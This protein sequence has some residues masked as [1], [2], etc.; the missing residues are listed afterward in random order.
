MNPR[1]LLLELFHEALRSVDGER[2][3]AT[4]LGELRPGPVALFAI[5]K[6]A[7]SMT[8]GAFAALGDDVQQTLIITKDGHVDP[9]VA[10]RPRVR[11]IE[12]AHPIPDERSL[13]AGAELE[14][15][16]VELPRG[17]YP[18]FLVSGGSSSLV[19]SLRAG[20]TL[21][22]LRSLNVR[23]MG[24]GWDIARLN[25]ERGKLS[26]IKGG[27]VAALLDGRP[28]HAL[29]ISDV[30]GDDP[31]V[32][33][34][35][36]LGPA[37]GR[38]DR[39]HRLVV[40]NVGAATRCVADAARARGVE[41]EERRASF[42]GEAANVA[43]EFLDALRQTRADGLV[44]GGESTVMLPAN[45]GRGGRNQHLALAAARALRAGESFTIL[46]AGTDGTDGPTDDAGA[47]VDS[48]TVERAELGGADVERALRDYDSGLALEAAQDLLHTGPTGTNVGDLLIGIKQDAPRARDP[49]LPRML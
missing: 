30:P 8:L 13:A 44:W 35:G 16:L 2:S 37:V 47:I 5:G 48:L 33:G 29:F 41:L 1:R 27:G 20:S 31:G 3:V 46:A 24:S 39:V 6:A 4:A 10:T 43:A 34:S 23:G 7:S 18:I 15:Q 9:R 26:R 38:T 21:D 49:T 40:A 36:L 22:D 17:V 28:A 32:I 19:E 14:R 42:E 11:V 12:S 25:T 45:P